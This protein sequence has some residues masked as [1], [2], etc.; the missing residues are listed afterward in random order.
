MSGSQKYIVLVCLGL[1]GCTSAA[2]TPPTS[3]PAASVV[4]PTAPSLAPRATRTPVTPTSTPVL[5]PTNEVDDYLSS[6]TPI[7]LLPLGRVVELES[8]RMFDGFNGWATGYAQGAHAAQE[9]QHV[10][11]TQDGGKTWVDVTPDWPAPGPATSTYGVKTF[12]LDQQRAWVA[13]MPPEYVFGS[14][15][16]NIAGYRMPPLII[17]R[18]DDGGQ[19][20]QASSVHTPSPDRY[21]ELSLF[22]FADALSGW[23]SIDVSPSFLGPEDQETGYWAPT[24][25][26]RTTDGGLTWE[27]VLSFEDY[28]E[29]DL[30]R[31]YSKMVDFV[32][33]DV[34]VLALESPHRIS[35]SAVGWTRDGGFTWERQDLPPPPGMSQEQLARCTSDSP[36]LFNPQRLNILLR[37]YPYSPD[38]EIGFL[39]ATNDGGASW[40]ISQLGPQDDPAV[41]QHF[42]LNEDVGWTYAMESHHHTDIYYTEDGGLHW[43]KVGETDWDSPRIR[44]VS[45]Q[46]GFAYHVFSKLDRVFRTA[47]GGATWEE[48]TPII[49]QALG[50]PGGP[51]VLCP[52]VPPSRVAEG[53]LTRVTYTDGSSL[54]IRTEAG[55]STGER[56]DYL[57]EG[58][59]MT[60]LDGPVCADGFAWWQVETADALTG[61]VAEGDWEA[62]FLEPLE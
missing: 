9:F 8:L 7:E 17:W 25:L 53:F 20:W 38:T 43:R 41:Y 62:Y 40:R 46:I 44:F 57:P 29:A 23:L 39:Y 50:R 42:Y 18:T 15:G 59:R 16:Y 11:R 13:H 3:M 4:A 61:W 56:I 45:R 12:F 31:V 21:T 52:D 51:V 36:F 58:T 19:T 34:G 37:C 47:D 2:Q 22:H 35:A 48:I 27:K 28:P 5:L 24:L 33:R 60:I 49:G 14:D 30:H 10:L 55:L 1:I 32:N 26:L 6:A 54:A